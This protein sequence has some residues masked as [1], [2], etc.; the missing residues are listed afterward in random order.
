MIIGG[1]DTGADCLGTAHRQGAASVHQFEILPRPPDARAT[2]NPWPQWPLIYRT[3]S[4]HEEGGERVFCVNTEC[5]LGDDEGHLRAL[6][7]HEV[8]DGR[9]AA[10]RRSRA[11]TSSSV[12]AGPAGHGLRRAR[13]GHLLDQLGVEPS[14]TGA[15]W[16]AT[17]TS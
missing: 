16:P 10:S 8:A 7:A 4:A 12:R 15:T 2:T 1:G 6:R 14:T 11:P 3:S 9:R 17:P 5:F 13:E